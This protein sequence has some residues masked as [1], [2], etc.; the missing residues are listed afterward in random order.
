MKYDCKICLQVQ[1]PYAATNWLLKHSVLGFTRTDKENVIRNAGLCLEL[2]KDSENK[3]MLT[4]FGFH[5]IALDSGNIFESLDECRIAGMKLDTD[6]GK[7]Y[8]NP[9]VW[10]TGTRYF[11]IVTPFNVNLEICQRL[12]IQK[13][14][15]HTI[16][17]LEHIG[18]LA[19]DVGISENFYIDIGFTQAFPRTEVKNENGIEVFCSMMEL[20]NVNVEI[21]SVSG[22]KYVESPWTGRIN[23]VSTDILLRS[24]EGPDGEHICCLN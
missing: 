7:P 17:G 14:R 24:A 10:G 22:K 18:L 13:P 1:D 23:S 4:N 12:D 15:A 6:G 2:K 9:K 19:K 11:N 16:W 5:H 21:F 20:G 3:S 8:L